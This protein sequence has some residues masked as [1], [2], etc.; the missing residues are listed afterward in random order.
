MTNQTYLKLFTTPQQGSNLVDN[1]LMV[2]L[3]SNLTVNT[4]FTYTIVYLVLF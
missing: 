4:I 1:D 3:A 2:K